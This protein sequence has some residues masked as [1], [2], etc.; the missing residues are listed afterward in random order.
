[1]SQQVPALLVLAGLTALLV[2][3]LWRT[4]RWRAG[5]AA[6]VPLLG[7]L[8]AAPRRYL[9]HVHEVVIRDPLGSVGRRDSGPRI[10]RMHILTAGGFVAATL[11]ILLVHGLGIGGPVLAWLLL[12]VLAAMAIG[13]M[14]VLLRRADPLPAR[15]SE[16]GFNRLPWS[17]VAFIVFFVLVTLPVTG[18]TGPIDWATIL[19][20][21]LLL[22]GLWACL[23]LYPGMALGPMKHAL[24]GFLHL[25]WH[26]RPAR[27][28]PGVRDTALQPL[29]LAAPQL[30]ARTAQD[31]PW[32]RLLSFDA[33]VQC[34]R[35]EAACPAFAA[36]QPLSPKAFIQ[37]LVQGQT[38]SAREQA[39]VGPD[40]LIHPDTLWACTTC[41][42]CVYECPMMIEHVDAVVELRRFETLEKGMTPGKAPAVLEELRATDTVSGKPS[43]SRLDWAVDLKLPLLADKGECELLFWLGE[44]AYELRNQRTLRA[45]VKL[46]RQAGVDFA[47][48]GAEELDCGDLA[49]RLGDEAT[50]QA[51]AR[52]NIAT[53]SRYRFRRILTIDPHVLHTLGKEYPALGGHYT[54]V[55]H[56]TLLAELLAEGRLNPSP[57]ALDGPVTL[58][59]PCYLGRY[60]GELAAPRTLLAGI[61][62]KVVEM[63]RSGLR[64]SC[65]GWGGGA[66]YTDVPGER[67]IPDVRMDHARAVNAAVVAVACPNCAVML[68][69]V[70]QPRPQVQDIAELLAAA[71]EKSA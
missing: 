60:H 35:C 57:L 39:L 27:F 15:L 23:E 3:A 69:G 18:L 50:F 12:V 54:V 66:V 2:G 41:R 58:H 47:V 28:A 48:L 59:D 56:T 38:D 68:E 55:H 34:G 32:N 8:L 63:E 46:L 7:G 26:P 51:L 30:G 70:V 42:A 11:L 40:A 4:S 44:G 6:A 22:V 53:L 37:K 10:A 14:L 43:A 65:C 5:R 49:R 17:L 24:N 9:V 52:R 71:L 25:A 20:A 1:M 61:G 16:G 13:V 64:S 36:G 45:V 31:F 62:V 33:C 29:N 67:R 21:E 19:A